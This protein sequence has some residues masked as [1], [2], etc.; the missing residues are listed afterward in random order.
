MD[1]VV[2]RIVVVHLHQGCGHQVEKYH[3]D[4]DVV[5]IV[6]DD[7]DVDGVQEFSPNENWGVT[8]PLLPLNLKIGRNE[9]KN[10]KSKRIK[11][12]TTKKKDKN[13]KGNRLTT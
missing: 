10:L 3:K 13:S 12:K 8:P 11:R 5:D 9:D 7:D 4:D 6:G 1:D 2:C